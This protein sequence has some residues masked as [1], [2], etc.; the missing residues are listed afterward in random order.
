M[1]EQDKIAQSVQS[2][3]KTAQKQNEKYSKKDLIWLMLIRLFIAVILFIIAMPSICRETMILHGPVGL[4]FWLLLHSLVILFVCFLFL[5]IIHEMVKDKI[6][7]KYIGLFILLVVL[8]IILIPRYGSEC[9]N[10]FQ[11]L[12]SGPTEVTVKNYKLDYVKYIVGKRSRSV[13]LCY[14]ILIDSPQ[15][16]ERIVF[17]LKTLNHMS[18]YYIHGSPF[19]IMVY[20]NTGIIADQE[21]INILKSSSRLESP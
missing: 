8:F 6:I 16:V 21:S 19:S 4:I 13:N 2:G 11:D 1:T 20:P 7:K 5:I 10:V 15:D 18:N 12:V 17:P 9:L 14:Q 3:Q